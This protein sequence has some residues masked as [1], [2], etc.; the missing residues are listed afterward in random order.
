MKEMKKQKITI[1]TKVEDLTTHEINETQKEHIEIIKTWDELTNEEKE[2]EIEKNSELI[3][4]YYQDEIFAGYECDLADL[5]ERYKNIDFE[6]VYLDS[7]SQGGWIDNVKGFKYY[8][9][10]IKI[11]GEDIEINDIYLH[12]CK[13]IKKIDINDIDIYDYYIGSEK[14]EKIQASK[15]YQKWMQEIIQDVN[16]WIEEVND[17]ASFIIKNLYCYPYNLNDS[18]DVYFLDNFFADCEFTYTED[19]E[20]GC[21]ENG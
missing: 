2:K 1:T 4:Q 13:Y 14:L 15:K 11:Y 19:I 8:A 5:K 20:K 17:A 12:I 18:E 21:E 6:D 10:P 16:N 7:N 3:Y 9:K